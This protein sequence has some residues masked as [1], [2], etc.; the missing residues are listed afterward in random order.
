MQGLK[1]IPSINKKS[2]EMIERRNESAK[3]EGEYDPKVHTR[4]YSQ[5]LL[6]NELAKKT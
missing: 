4:L 5:T 6:K 2:I 3:Q 1:E